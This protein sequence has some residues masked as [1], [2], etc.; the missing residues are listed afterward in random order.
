MFFFIFLLTYIYI[1]VFRKHSETKT[2]Q[3][4]QCPYVTTT[5]ETL[6]KHRNK[7]HPTTAMQSYVIQVCHQ[8]FFNKRLPY[9]CEGLDLNI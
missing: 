9:M 5:K 6:S 2:A 3:C 4:D 7:L 8:N 1:Y